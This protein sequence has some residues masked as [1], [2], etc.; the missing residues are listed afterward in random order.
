M[1]KEK[2]LYF[3]K[4]NIY[5]YPNIKCEQIILNGGS[6]MIFGNSSLY[7]HYKEIVSFGQM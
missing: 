3:R 7:I 6:I 5:F 4:M 2:Y 1:F